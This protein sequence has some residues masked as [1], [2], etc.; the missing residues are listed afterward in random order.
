MTSSKYLIKTIL[1]LLLILSISAC[2]ALAQGE[3]VRVS[4]QPDNTDW[5][6]EDF[7]ARA[8]ER[9]VSAIDYRVTEGLPRR[10]F[11]RDSVAATLTFRFRVDGRGRLVHFDQLVPRK[12]YLT[13]LVRRTVRESYIFDRLPEDFPLYYFDGVMTVNCLF[14]PTGRYKRF[15]FQEPIDSLEHVD[16]ITIL[17]PP[18]TELLTLYEPK[19]VDKKA[20]LEQY[21]KISGSWNRSP[22]QAVT[23][24]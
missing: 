12:R 17:E 3:L 23:H 6:W 15:Y 24:H 20:L 18:S 7:A 1:G 11:V 4:I 16:E 13:Y 14:R 19:D 2:E 22:T 5:D 10:E 8:A 9:L 21:K